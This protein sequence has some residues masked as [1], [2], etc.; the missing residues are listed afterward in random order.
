[1]NRTDADR[2]RRLLAYVGHELRNPLAAAVVSI[3]LV[4]ELVDEGDPRRAHLSR[5]LVELER[6]AD[7]LTSL[8][9]FGRAGAPEQRSAGLAQ[10]VRRVAERVHPAL[11]EIRAPTDEVFVQGDPRLL[12]QAVE[13]LVRNSI[14]AGATLVEIMVDREPCE[15]VLHIEDNGPGVPTDLNDRIFMPMVSGRG[16]SGLGLAMAREIIEAHGGSLT[17]L[18]TNSG[19]LFRISLPV[20]T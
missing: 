18:P 16:S 15:A 11:V 1:M 19:A 6:V 20:S 2:D 4:N 17:L 9:A 8:L 3:S 10:L 12:E 5:A 13:N 14:A 7:L